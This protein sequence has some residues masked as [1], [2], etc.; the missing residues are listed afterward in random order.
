M[1]WPVAGTLMIEAT[2]SED[3]AELDRFCDARISIRQEIADIEEGPINPRVNPLRRSPHSL[4]CFMSSH[5]DRP[6]SREVAAFPPPLM[7]PENKFWPIITWIDDVCGDQHM[8]CT[9][10]PMVVYEFPF[11][12]FFKK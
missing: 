12:F 7:K 10:P 6:H 4:S 11:S 9:C 5:W 1:S 3:K 8:V 2:E